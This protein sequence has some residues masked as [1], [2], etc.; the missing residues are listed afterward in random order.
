VEH[1]NTR[2]QWA[3]RGFTWHCFGVRSAG[4]RR[5]APTLGC[6]WTSH[7]GMHE[8]LQERKAHGTKASSQER[9]EPRMV[10]GT[11]ARR[12]R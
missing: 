9:T 4:A 3:A 10:H 6:A 7:H 12:L 11:V 1:R 5:S 2:A 8:H